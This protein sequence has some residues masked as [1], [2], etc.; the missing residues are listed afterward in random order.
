M[1]TLP[2]VCTIS[3]TTLPHTV[4]VE[5]K[6]LIGGIPWMQPTSDGYD[7]N[8][9][10]DSDLALIGPWQFVVWVNGTELAVIY[11]LSDDPKLLPSSGPLFPFKRLA[12]ATSPDSSASYLYHQINGTTFAEEQWDNSTNQWLSSSYIT[13]PAL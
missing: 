3:S 11:F 12:S 4:I 5:L 10:K 7:L 2:K 9:I 13:V 1:G 6:K 8:G